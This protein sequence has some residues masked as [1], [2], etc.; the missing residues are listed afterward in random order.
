MFFAAGVSARLTAQGIQGA[1]TNVTGGTT[2]FII[3]QPTITEKVAMNT[4]NNTSLTLIDDPVFKKM[5]GVTKERCDQLI[6]TSDSF[7]NFM[8]SVTT[9]PMK[10]TSS[11]IGGIKWNRFIQ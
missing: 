11:T 4:F 6:E 8:R 10:T 9:T 7:G 5:S 2:N 1:T 3:T